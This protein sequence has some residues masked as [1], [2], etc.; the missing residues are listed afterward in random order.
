MTFSAAFTSLR[1][2]IGNPTLRCIRPWAS[3]AIPTGYTYSATYKRYVNA[4]GTVWEP[5][6]SS[7]LYD[8]VAI[9]PGSG[10]AGVELVAAGMTDTGDRT[11]RILP[12]SLTT[13]DAAA[14]YVIDG[15]EYVKTEVSPFPSG[16]PQWYT[17]RMIKR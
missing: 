13:V 12:A 14:F 4:G 5:A 8:D 6:T 7:L 3:Q 17:V 15:F 2:M 9:L 10:S 16:R 1:A 11:V